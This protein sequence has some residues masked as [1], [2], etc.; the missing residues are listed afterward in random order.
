MGHTYTSCLFHVVFS[1]KERRPTI[2]PELQARL[3]PYLAGIARANRFHALE[4]GGT[5]DHV[6]LLLALPAT[7]PIAKAVQLLKGGS[8]RW[9]HETFPREQLFAWQDG[10]GAF[11]VGVSGV[12]RTTTYIRAQ[13]AHHRRRTFQDEFREFLTKHG[14][15]WDEKYVWG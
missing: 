13:A 15:E 4:V 2:T 9:A 1:T 7:M 5:P 11:T 8:S 3:Y 14:I 6:H 10:Y 12:A